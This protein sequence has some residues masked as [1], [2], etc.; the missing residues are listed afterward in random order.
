M[1]NACGLYQRSRNVPR[2]TIARRSTPLSTIR[3]RHSTSPSPQSMA[4][5]PDRPPPYQPAADKL[6]SCPGGGTCNGTGG[7]DGCSGCPALNNRISK[8]PAPQPRDETHSLVNGASKPSELLQ[9]ATAD[10]GPP[11]VAAGITTASSPILIACT[12]CGTTVTPLWRRDEAGHPICNACGLYH[13]LHGSQRP[14]QL[15]K[16]TIKRRKRVVPAYPPMSTADMDKINGDDRG[17]TPG[18]QSQPASQ[19][20]PEYVEVPPY[21]DDASS[22]PPPAKRPRPPPEIDFT[23][24]RP[25][26]H[27]SEPPQHPPE[28]P[29]SA[30]LQRA[31]AAAEE[32]LQLDPVLL[33]SVE[34]KVAEQEGAEAS[35]TIGRGQNETEDEWRTRRRTQLVREMDDLRSSLRAKEKEIDDLR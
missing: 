30:L 35:T 18:M 22:L 29:L 17:P 2:P 15:K 13:K 28:E 25:D 6:G 9:E 31:A 21:V 4:S 24:Y 32:T 14:V 23:G 12:N 19:G 1:C 7:A 20:M 26:L 11:A 33:A 27:S 5:Q 8:I 16:G 3:Q 34:V 10:T